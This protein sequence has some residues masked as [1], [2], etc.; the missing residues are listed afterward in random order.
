MSADY[1]D[2]RP[3]GYAERSVH[4]CRKEQ[5]QIDIYH[6]SKWMMPEATRVLRIGNCFYRVVTIKFVRLDGNILL[7]V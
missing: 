1:A 3:Q 6:R 5:K 2:I 7:A 4:K